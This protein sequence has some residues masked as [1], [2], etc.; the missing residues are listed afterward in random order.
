MFLIREFVPFFFFFNN[1]TKE[2]NP[3][4]S[5]EHSVTKTA[6]RA[7]ERLEESRARNSRNAT[8]VAASW[9][10]Q[11]PQQRILRLDGNNKRRGAHRGI[12]SLCKSIWLRR[13]FLRIHS[14]K[15]TSFLI[16]ISRPMLGAAFFS[17]RRSN[18]AYTVD[19]KLLLALQNML[20]ECKSNVR[21]FKYTLETS[22]SHDISCII[23]ADK[24]PSSEQLRR[25]NAPTCNDVAVLLHGDQHKPRDIVLHCRHSQLQRVSET[26]RLYNAL[27]YPLLFPYTDDV[28]HVGTPQYGPDTTLSVVYPSFREACFR[29]GLLQD[30]TQWDYTLAEGVLLRSPGCLR[31]LF[32]ILLQWCEISDLN[33]LWERY[34]DHMSED[35][36]RQAQSHNPDIEVTFSGIIY[37]RAL[38]ALEDSLLEVGGN[39]LATYG[40][41]PIHCERV[42]DLFTDLLRETSLNV[43]ELQ[44]YFWPEQREDFDAIV[45]SVRYQTGGIFFLDASG[46]TGK[47]FVT[48]LVLAEL[49]RAD[50]I[51][52]TVASSGIA[53]TLPPEKRLLTQ[54]LSYLST[55]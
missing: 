44:I 47:A 18:P 38:I 21:S 32:A 37:N 53:D 54:H 23:D 11:T 40:L 10:S 13:A 45:D 30:D 26:H 49:R 35:F 4:G 6:L 27:Q 3:I 25:Y 50:Y 17:F 55:W 41:P 36:L 12:T 15:S 9:S 52:L 28:Y 42:R 8:A 7:R 24:R 33:S 20:H 39:T 14:S 51:A 34:K 19:K 48:K 31:Y 29:R 2:E 46:D 22:S 5:V 1:A 43:E 16:T